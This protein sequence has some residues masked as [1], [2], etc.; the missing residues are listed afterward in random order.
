MPFTPPRCAAE[1]E[2][3]SGNCNP[4]SCRA[5]TRRSRRRLQ[6]LSA[7]PGGSIPPRRV[8]EFDGGDCPSGVFGDQGLR[9]GRRPLQRGE[10]GAVA[11][12][13]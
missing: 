6:A 7:G 13:A 12:I 3:G 1:A 10:N 9:I 5:T 11:D 4:V 2:I 8:T